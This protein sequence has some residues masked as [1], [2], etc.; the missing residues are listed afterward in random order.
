MTKDEMLE[1]ADRL[2]HSADRLARLINI[3]APPI[4]I[5]RE[6]LIG[7]SILTELDPGDAALTAEARGSLAEGAPE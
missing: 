6:R 5:E 3:D 1:Q 7:L 4:V 2:K